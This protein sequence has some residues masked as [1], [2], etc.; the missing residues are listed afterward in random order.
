MKFSSSGEC[1]QDTTVGSMCATDDKPDDKLTLLKHKYRL[2]QSCRSS[3]I[4][5]KDKSITTVS[6][7]ATGVSHV[8]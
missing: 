2:Q 4:W 6:A 3:A 8:H 5:S 1:S 7:K